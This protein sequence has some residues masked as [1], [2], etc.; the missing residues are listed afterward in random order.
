MQGRFHYYEGHA[1]EHIAYG[2]RTFK[3]LDAA[4]I[5]MSGAAGTMRK[6]WRKGD[7]MMINDHIHLLPGNPLIG[8]NDE[9]LGPRFPDMSEAY[10]T[11]LQHHLMEAALSLGIELRS[12][13]Y[14]SAQGPMLETAAEYRFLSRIGA[15]AVGMS[16]T[17]EVIVANHSG[18]P[19]AC[20]V[21]LTDECDPDDLQP[22]DIPEL[23]AV[24][25][26]AEKHLIQLIKTVIPTID[27]E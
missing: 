10:D 4:F 23:L 12:G 7:L 13:V 8:V 1:F 9:R 15:D 11:S 18:I 25:A 26:K 21:V 5:I 3:A 22:I 2:I 27:A 16:T 14:V 6:D 19:I 17:P 24:A 20:V